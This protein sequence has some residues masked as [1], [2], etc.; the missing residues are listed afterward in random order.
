[1]T[2]TL[3]TL[4]LFPALLAGALHLMQPA[5]ILLPFRQPADVAKRRVGYLDNKADDRNLPLVSRQ[6][7]LGQLML[8]FYSASFPSRLAIRL[9]TF[10]KDQTT[11]PSCP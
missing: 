11:L 10:S 2:G 9:P 1:M 8:R 4:L 3:L 6:N 7:F 5:M